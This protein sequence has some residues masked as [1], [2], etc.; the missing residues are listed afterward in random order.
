MQVPAAHGSPILSALFYAGDYCGIKLPESR[1]GKASPR[2]I[3]PQRIDA[4]IAPNGERLAI[5]AQLHASVIFRSITRM[6][7]VPFSSFSPSR[8]MPW[9]IVRPSHGASF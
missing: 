8:C 7:I 3:A 6:R 2:F 5:G 9:T 4:E 1:V